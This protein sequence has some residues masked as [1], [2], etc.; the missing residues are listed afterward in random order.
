MIPGIITTANFDRRYH[1][2]PTMECIPI[3]PSG[4]DADDEQA[5]KA[6]DEKWPREDGKMHREGERYTVV[7]VKSKLSFALFRSFGQ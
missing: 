5:E 7:E 1:C 4:A 6:D 3:A 2:Q